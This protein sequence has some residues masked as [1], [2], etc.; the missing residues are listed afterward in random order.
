MLPPL[1]SVSI[2]RAVTV[3]AQAGEDIYVSVIKKPVDKL[4]QPHWVK[5]SSGRSMYGMQTGYPYEETLV[6]LTSNE[7]KM[8]LSILKGYDFKSG[9][10]TVNTQ[11]LSASE[12][13]VLSK[14]YTDLHKRGLVK[15]VKKFTYL[16][17]PNARIHSNYDEHITLW[18]SLP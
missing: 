13:N 16:I 18:E 11:S 7:S 3:V 8:Y 4:P 1:E 10:S 12:K 9:L 5:T 15:R 6:S 14:G 17:N 2:G